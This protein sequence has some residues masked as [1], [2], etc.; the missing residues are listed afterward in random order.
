[1][2]GVVASLVTLYW[3]QGFLYHMLGDVSQS[4]AAYRQVLEIAQSPQQSA[5]S[6]AMDALLYLGFLYQTQ[7]LWDQALA[8][9]E[10]AIKL[11]QQLRSQHYVS[12]VHY[13]V[14]NLFSKQGRLEET[15]EFYKQA[16]ATIEK[17]RGAIES[18]EIKIGLL[19]TTQ[20]V[21]ESIVLLCLN[22]G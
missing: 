4:E 2:L 20:Q 6:A 5:P 15:M 10:Q 9:Y 18:E 21:Y 19:G 7:E 11:A 22:Q 12:F 14:G 17:L 1:S 16:I 13:R 3:S 8:A